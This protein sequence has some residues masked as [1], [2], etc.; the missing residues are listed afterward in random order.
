MPALRGY[1]STR[2]RTRLEVC[3]S[4]RRKLL[5]PVGKCGRLG[6]T[7]QNLAIDVL[8]VIVGAAVRVREW[9]G[10]LGQRRRGIEEKAAE[11]HR[12]N[13]GAVGDR[14][15][16]AASHWRRGQLIEAWN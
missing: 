13:A 8:D 6:V 15:F 7:S 1:E 3:G 2:P 12:H 11:V 14:D 16:L 9:R 5:V 10:D 4:V